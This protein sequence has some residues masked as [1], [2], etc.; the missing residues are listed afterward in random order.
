MDSRKRTNPTWAPPGA[1]YLPRL[2]VRRALHS[3]ARSPIMKVTVA[4]STHSNG[5]QN[6]PCVSSQLFTSSGM[7]LNL[8]FLLADCSVH[9]NQPATAATSDE[10]MHSQST[11]AHSKLEVFRQRGHPSDKVPPGLAGRKSCTLLLDLLL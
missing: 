11:R 2:C 5:D 10:C 6:I 8:P 9:S 7:I 4:R 3:I 1:S